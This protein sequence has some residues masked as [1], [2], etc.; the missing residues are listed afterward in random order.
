MARRL[1]HHEIKR[2]VQSAAEAGAINLDIPVRSLLDS[3]ASA[4]PEGGGTEEVGLHI[5]CCNEYALITHSGL[6]DLEAIVA[7]AS[8]IRSSLE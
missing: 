2:A 4:L 7:Q 3:I 5:L 8:N 1:A 6:S